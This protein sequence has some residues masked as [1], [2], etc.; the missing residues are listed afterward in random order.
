M[1]RHARSR[2]LVGVLDGIA[3]ARLIP[4]KALGSHPLDHD[5][6]LELELDP[7]SDEQRRLR[8]RRL[9]EFVGDLRLLG[10]RPNILVA[11]DPERVAPVR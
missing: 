3:A 6:L 9:R 4:V 5:W 10:T 1:K 7:G 2:E 8:D 11:E